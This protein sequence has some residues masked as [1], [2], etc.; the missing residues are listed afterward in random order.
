MFHIVKNIHTIVEAQFVII[1]SLFLD[2]YLV[3]EGNSAAVQFCFIS[4]SR[5]SVSAHAL[6][7]VTSSLGPLLVP[8][9]YV[10]NWSQNYNSFHVDRIVIHIYIPMP[11]LM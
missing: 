8:N 3:T 9:N 6:S 10:T 2:L 11:T 1:V 4:S 7:A 5:L